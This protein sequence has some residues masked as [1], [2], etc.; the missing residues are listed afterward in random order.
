MCSVGLTTNQ[1]NKTRTIT[2]FWND[3][4][5]FWQPP[6]HCTVCT[7]MKNMI[8]VFPQTLILFSADMNGQADLD[9]DYK[10]KYKN[11]KRKL[12]F[13]VYVSKLCFCRVC[14]RVSDDPSL[15]LVLVHFRSK[16]VFKKSWEEPRESSWRSPE[17]KG[18]PS[19]LFPLC[20]GIYLHGY[21]GTDVP[22][23]FSQFPSGPIVT[24]RTGGW[25]LVWWVYCPEPVF[26]SP[27]FLAGHKWQGCHLVTKTG[28]RVVYKRSEAA[29]ASCSP[30]LEIR[31]YLVDSDNLKDRHL[32]REL[33]SLT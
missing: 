30:P 19:K 33:Q 2:M 4:G 21:V 20:N 5:P 8:C 32:L 1:R 23:L 11:L 18:S 9:V 3:Y 29:A 24:V 14:C 12:K 31:V 26:I 10:R 13:L 27:R 15:H 16:N 22:F 17:I 6:S 28:S 25:G 7:R